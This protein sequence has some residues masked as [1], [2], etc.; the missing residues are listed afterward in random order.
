MNEENKDWVEITEGEM[1]SIVQD[2]LRKGAEGFIKNVK[3]KKLSRFQKIQGVDVGR[4]LLLMSFDKLGTDAIELKIIVDGIKK[5]KKT[6]KKGK[7]VET[8]YLPKKLKL[9]QIEDKYF[10]RYI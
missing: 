8:Y 7:T 5:I 1:L 10:K 6:L 9:K 2:D 4:K 3:N